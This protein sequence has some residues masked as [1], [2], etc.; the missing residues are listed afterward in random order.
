MNIDD[1]IDDINKELDRAKNLHPDWPSDIVHAAA[2]VTEE[3]GE[4]LQA[5]N[6]YLETGDKLYMV[7]CIKEAVQTGAMAIRFLENYEN[8]MEVK[9]GKCK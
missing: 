7:M 8:L 5:A 1:I 6:S 4:L 9:N 2:K 3:A